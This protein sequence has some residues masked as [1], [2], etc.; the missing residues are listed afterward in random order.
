MKEHLKETKQQAKALE[1]RIKALGGKP[2]TIDVPGPDVVAEAAGKAAS[3]AQKGLALAKAPVHALRGLSPEETELKNA[4]TDFSDEHEEIATYT[5]IETL[6]DALGDKDTAKLAREHRKQEEKMASFLQRQIPTLAKA[7]ATKEVPAAERRAASGSH[8][9][10][11]TRSRSTSSAGTSRSASRSTSSRSTSGGSGSGAATRAKSSGTTRSKPAGTTRA[12]S[13]GTTRSKSSGTTRAKSGATTTRAS[14]ASR[15]GSAT[16][17]AAA[18][19]SGTTKS[20]GTSRGGAATRASGSSRSSGTTS[21][22]TSA[23]SGTSR[24]KAGAKK[25]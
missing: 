22:S 24:A 7:V 2:E 16:K 3:V 15:G 18:S 12:K 8:R 13:S 21:R 23:R 9:R 6:A 11:T 14:A 1:R 4:K 20:S 17:P 19:R 5:A 10:T 25:S